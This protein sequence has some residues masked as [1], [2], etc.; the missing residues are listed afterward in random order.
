[1][2]TKK[3]LLALLVAALCINF[4]SCEDNSENKLNKRKKG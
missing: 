4:I 1:M 2:E 3:T